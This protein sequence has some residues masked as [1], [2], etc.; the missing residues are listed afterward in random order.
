MLDLGLELSPSKG[1]ES[2]IGVF[3]FCKRMI[4]PNC[5]FSPLGMKGISVALRSPNYLTSLF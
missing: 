2:P 3:E 4:G 1:F 5:E